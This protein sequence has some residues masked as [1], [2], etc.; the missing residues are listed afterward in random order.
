MVRR[1]PLS[2][3]L[4]GVSVLLLTACA[5]DSPPPPKPTPA[6]DPRICAPIEP[7]PPVKGALVQPV[8]E[9]EQSDFE[10]FVSGEWASRAWGRRGWGR[11]GIAREQFCR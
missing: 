3:F 6:A 11:A 8:T 4:L 7:E 9:V 10:A 5:H 2:D 1:K